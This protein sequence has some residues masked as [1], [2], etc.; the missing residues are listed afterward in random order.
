MKIENSVDRGQSAETGL[1]IT[2]WGVIPET[3]WSRRGRTH[4][5]TVPAERKSWSLK[6]KA[7]KLLII[8]KFSY[9]NF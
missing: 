8:L 7:M 9:D 6:A 4:R 3:I 5:F 2:H 1:V